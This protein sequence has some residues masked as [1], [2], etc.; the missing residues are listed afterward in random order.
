[1]EKYIYKI[2]NKENGLI[3]IG[4]T[5]NP[6]KRY[7]QHFLNAR[8][9]EDEKNKILYQALTPETKENFEWTILEGP[10]EN[11]NERERY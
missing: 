3:Y 1:M 9:R 2:K 7:K 10:I 5:K 11:Y 4:Q 8:S 6:D